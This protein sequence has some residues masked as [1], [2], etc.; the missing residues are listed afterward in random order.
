MIYLFN[1]PSGVLVSICFAMSSQLPKPN[2][3]IASNSLTS[4]FADQ[5]VLPKNIPNAPESL[6]Y[7][8]PLYKQ[9][10]S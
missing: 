1:L 9:S 6:K 8:L 7:R 2:C 4:S 10:I 5:L 3:S